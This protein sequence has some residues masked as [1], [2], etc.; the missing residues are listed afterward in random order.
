[1]T[2][3]ET[4]KCKEQ[5]DAIAIC[6][7]Y[8]SDDGI[9]R[10]NEG[11]IELKHEGVWIK[12]CYL[13]G[14]TYGLDKALA[15]VAC[16]QLGYKFGIEGVGMSIFRGHYGN[17]DIDCDG[18]EQKL[19][20]CKRFRYDNEDK[21]ACMHRLIVICEPK[22]RLR[23]GGVTSGLKAGFLEISTP[24]GWFQACN[25][26]AYQG[27]KWLGLETAF[28]TMIDSIGQARPSMFVYCGKP[29]SE[30][31]SQCRSIS[32]GPTE[33]PENPLWTSCSD[34]PLNSAVSD[35]VIKLDEGSYGELK[36]YV[37]GTW[38]AVCN[39]RQYVIYEDWA[40][41]LA[42]TVCRQLGYNS[43]KK[44]VTFIQVRGRS[45]VSQ[46]FLYTDISCRGTQEHL[47]ECQH[48]RW[49]TGMGSMC[50]SISV[51]CDIPSIRLS[52]R[53]HG[54]VQLRFNDS[55]WLPVCKHWTLGY[56]YTW[57]REES[58]VLCKHLG[59]KIGNI[60]TYRYMT[61]YPGDHVSTTMK[62]K[63]SE[64][65]LHE[66][67]RFLW[68]LRGPSFDNFYTVYVACDMSKD[69]KIH[70][71]DPD[72]PSGK[73][74]F[75]E[76]K[77]CSDKWTDIEASA[78]CENLGF[79]PEHAISVF[80]EQRS[81]RDFLG[82]SWNSS[83]FECSKSDHGF[84]CEMRKSPLCACE[85]CN[86]GV[87]CMGHKP[88]I[89]EYIKVMPEFPHTGQVEVHIPNKP[90]GSICATGWG[91]KETQV[92]C[93][94]AGAFNEV[95]HKPM[96]TGVDTNNIT[97][98]REN[99]ILLSDVKCHGDEANIAECNFKFG[100]EVSCIFKERASVFCH[101]IPIWMPRSPR[102]GLVKLNIGHQE[103]D[104]WRWLC[105]EDVDKN[106]RDVFC[107][108]VTCTR[109]SSILISRYG[110][111]IS[112]MRAYFLV[113]N[114]LKKYRPHNAF[115]WPVVKLKCLGHEVSI[116]QCELKESYNCTQLAVIGCRGSR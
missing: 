113:Y 21:R 53:T 1:M 4:Q 92:V 56:E 99:P 46:L 82:D 10:T 5:Q 43:S 34:E 37:N 86:I 63:G 39:D 59:L 75:L 60:L 105:G 30:K 17:Y 95:K 12:V 23:Q 107:F 101:R 88:G 42:K 22:F 57:G 6:K 55:M 110:V 106:T 73:P 33:C 26:P 69:V 66:C 49:K 111:P 100:D 83:S 45:P 77:L 62:C 58:R 102:R 68:S 104:K 32:R 78:I 41:R 7:K 84:E 48:T 67:E 87:Q 28:A 79:Q 50:R 91:I 80:Y 70:L 54:V 27:C 65:G 81:A 85:Y 89:H 13:H 98:G 94:Q 29:K 97:G 76:S 15:D 8:E 74:E 44:V 35:A 25:V 9:R 36:V 90:I 2:W 93:R 114:R 20:D 47:E 31:L 16:K 3:Q 11:M 64:S 52:E 116:G 61:M 72:G 38:L 40:F 18:T 19:Q 103:K 109:N 24:E 71:R 96:Y 51:S 14:H 115:H 108:F 112:K